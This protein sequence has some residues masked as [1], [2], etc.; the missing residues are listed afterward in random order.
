[1]NPTSKDCWAIIG[2]GRTGSKVIVDYVKNYYAHNNI[3]LNY[4]SPKIKVTKPIEGCII[5]THQVDSYPI[6]RDSNTKIIISTRDMVDSS[7][8]WCI[9][10]YIGAWHLYTMYQYSNVKITA[11]ELD[12]TEFYGHYDASLRFY[13]TLQNE[14]IQ[15]NPNV[16]VIDY[17]KFESNSNAIL[18]L[19]DIEDG[20][21]F[22]RK[23][24]KNPGSPEA[25]ISNW[26]N[27]QTELYRL[28]RI[29][30]IR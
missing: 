25:W 3:F 9:Q 22:K 29:P 30:E 26:H 6:L 18:T 10:K 1:M 28:K 12:F 4:Q 17:T 21:S 14:C 23:P 8:S 15:Y 5:H 13:R 27:I 19:L 20:G 24:L 11:F 16:V 2:P 7:L